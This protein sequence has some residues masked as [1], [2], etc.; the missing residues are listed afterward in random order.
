MQ[1]ITLFITIL[2]L[3]LVTPIVNQVG[4]GATAAA[5][6]SPAAGPVQKPRGD[7]LTEEFHQTYPLSPTGRVH[8]CLGPE[9]CEG[10]C[11]ETC[12]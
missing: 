10:R 1:R 11:G 2:A 5:G 7:E 6:N 9:F 8:Q 12:L 4:I 3:A